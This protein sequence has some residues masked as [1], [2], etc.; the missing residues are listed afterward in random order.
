[1]SQI[2]VDKLNK[3]VYPWE[4]KVKALPTPDLIMLKNILFVLS[5]DN[6]QRQRLTFLLHEMLEPKDNTTALG[7]MPKEEMRKL[8]HQRLHP[9]HER[10]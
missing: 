4:K 2:D 3:P 5:L 9:S 1:M 8:E 6:D 10:G 7:F